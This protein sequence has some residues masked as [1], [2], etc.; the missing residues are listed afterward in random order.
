MKRKQN[1]LKNKRETTK[2]NTNNKR[3]TK[4]KI[5]TYIA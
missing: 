5:Y 1:N 2:N 4:Q 3:K